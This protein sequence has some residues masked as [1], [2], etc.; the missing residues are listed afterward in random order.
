M[1]A[2]LHVKL[3]L[4]VLVYSQLYGNYLRICIGK[5]TPN[6]RGTMAVVPLNLIFNLSYK[7]I[8]GDFSVGCRK[9]LISRYLSGG[10]RLSKRKLL[11][12]TFFKSIVGISPS[13]QAIFIAIFQ[14]R[15]VSP[16]IYPTQC[17]TSPLTDKSGP[18]WT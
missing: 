7:K 18:S 4:I 3:T 14:L 12:F 10:F 15:E 17:L 6:C 5:C 2:N 1:S 13:I 9:K 8:S 11:I 16:L